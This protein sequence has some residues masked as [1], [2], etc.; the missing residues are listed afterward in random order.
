MVM[1]GDYLWTENS[2]N[3]NNESIKKI[4]KRMNK[5]NL[6]KIEM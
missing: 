4:E 1:E 3:K 2:K 5:K 6:N